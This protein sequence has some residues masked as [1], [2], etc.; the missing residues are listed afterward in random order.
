MSIT[1]VAAGAS[2]ERTAQP[3]DA[4]KCIR[5]WP[6]HGD[7]TRRFRTVEMPSWSPLK[8]SIVPETMQRN[9]RPRPMENARD[10]R[11]FAK[12][13]PMARLRDNV[14]AL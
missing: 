8:E 4:S 1:L 5:P 14:R 12:A 6:R 7:A 10:T 3:L 2:V 11:P 13:H 9:S